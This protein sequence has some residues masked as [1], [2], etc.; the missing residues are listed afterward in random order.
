FEERIRNIDSNTYNMLR[1]TQFDESGM[2]NAQAT[3]VMMDDEDINYYRLGLGSSG[4]PYIRYMQEN[5]FEADT[6][7]ILS[8][9]YRTEEIPE[10]DLTMIRVA[11]GG[12]ISLNSLSEGN[13]IYELVTDGQWTR[14]IV[15]F[16]PIE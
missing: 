14:L 7:Y 15:K 13:T 8:V 12:D 9:D 4:A 1:G 5:T 3:V 6:P 2:W 10:L 11:G 16:T